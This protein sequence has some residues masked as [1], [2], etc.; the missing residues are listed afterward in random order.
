LILG[1]GSTIWR[2]RIK[3]ATLGMVFIVQLS[4]RLICNNCALVAPAALDL[5][6]GKSVVWNSYVYML[7]S[8][9]AAHETSKPKIVLFDNAT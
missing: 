6:V 2:P 7:L 8:S 9:I 1:Q 4:G 5:T 3:T